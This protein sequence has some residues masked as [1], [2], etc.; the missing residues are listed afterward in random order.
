MHKAR[1]VPGWQYYQSGIYH[2]GLYFCFLS[3]VSSPIKR[4]Q[5]GMPDSRPGKPEYST[6]RHNPE[7]YRGPGSFTAVF[8]AILSWCTFRTFCGAPL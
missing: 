3:I 2:S 6:A 5:Q 1:V 4:L 8:S 7:D